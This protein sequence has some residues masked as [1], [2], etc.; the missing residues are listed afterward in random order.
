VR[1]NVSDGNA[2]QPPPIACSLTAT[3]LSSRVARWRDLAEQAD[4]RV[5][6]SE[7]GLRLTFT[8]RPGVAEELAELA[9]LERD[10]CAF[11][12]WAVV[13][14]G[15]HVVLNVTADADDAVPAVQGMFAE[16]AHPGR[17]D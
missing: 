2:A 4:V 10:C 5:S 13:R 14:T 11:A 7:R 16:L 9:E 8:A 6:R 15:D 1:N 12:D 3:D 17:A